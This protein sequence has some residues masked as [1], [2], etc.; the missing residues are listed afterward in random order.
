MKVTSYHLDARGPALCVKVY[1]LPDVDGSTETQQMRAYEMSQE[2]WWNVAKDIAREHGYKQ[3]YSAGRSAGWL[4]TDP[5]PP[6]D[7]AG[8]REYPPEFIAAIE[9]HLDRADE[10]YAEE[11]CSIM[12]ADAE[13]DALALQNHIDGLRE[14]LRLNLALR[15]HKRFIPRARG[16]ARQLLGEL[17][18][19]YAKRSPDHL[20]EVLRARLK[21][22]EYVGE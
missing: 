20:G 9:A 6:E 19:A 18:S 5:L 14:Q 22:T 8:N 16:K 17:R 7:D 21:K 10:L 15:N 2:C 11:L 1:T 13:R 4:Y 3:V 12:G